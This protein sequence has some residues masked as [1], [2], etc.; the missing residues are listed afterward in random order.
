MLHKKQAFRKEMRRI[1][2]SIPEALR[3]EKDKKICERISASECYK[4]AQAVFSYASYNSETSTQALNEMIR[5]DGKM[6]VLPKVISK[7]KMVF[8]EVKTAD[9]LVIGCM[10]IWEPDASKCSIFIPDQRCLMLIPGLAFD[11]DRYRMGYGGGYYDRYLSK[12]R[13]HLTCV[14]IAYDEQKADSVP[15]DQNDQRLDYIVTDKGIYQ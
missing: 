11:E 8:Y 1:R 15:H 2:A 10:G 5:S 6:L 12:Y 3:N 14:M 7:T 9:D 4:D 13:A